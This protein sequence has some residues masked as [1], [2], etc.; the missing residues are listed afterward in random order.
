MDYIIPGAGSAGGGF[1]VGAVVGIVAAWAVARWYYLKDGRAKL[2]VL[3]DEV[4]ALR[5]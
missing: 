2:K 3:E 5:G 1:L 4:K